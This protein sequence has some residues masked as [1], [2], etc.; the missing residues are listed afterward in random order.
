MRQW[1]LCIGC[2][3]FGALLGYLG[4]AYQWYGMAVVE[5]YVIGFDQ[6]YANG[7]SDASIP[8]AKVVRVSP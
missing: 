7:L 6:G 3:G 5:S 1:I 8:G 2:V 4:G